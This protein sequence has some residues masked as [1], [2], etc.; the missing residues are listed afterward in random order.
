[1]S[2]GRRGGERRPHAQSK[3]M[4]SRHGGRSPSDEERV[5]RSVLRPVRVNPHYTPGQKLGGG[6]L[7]S[8]SRLGK[9][10]SPGGTSTGVGRV[11]VARLAACHRFREEE[12]VARQKRKEVEASV[13]ARIRVPGFGCPHVVGTLQKSVGDVLASNK[14]GKR[15]P[16]RAAV[17]SEQGPSSERRSAGETV[18]RHLERRAR[19]ESGSP[20][21]REGTGRRLRVTRDRHPAVATSFEAVRRSWGRGCNGHRILGRVLTDRRR[22][23]S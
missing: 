4:H 10:G 2:E 13:P 14:L 15:A 23:G 22:S 7:S 16:K 20:V 9:P 17:S 12:G 1:M 18:D 19:R 21:T 5:L 3:R 6:A 8:A 11:G